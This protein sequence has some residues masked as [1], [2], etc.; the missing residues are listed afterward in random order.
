MKEIS[1][2]ELK[3]KIENK[4]DFQLIDVREDYEYEESNLKGEL[5]PLADIPD[6]MD[7]LSKDKPI[8]LYCKSGNRSS[9]ALQ[10]LQ[11]EGFKNVCMLTGGL[12]AWAKEI[13][14]TL[15]VY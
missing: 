14:T 7:K 2:Q 9:L 10:Y 1:A 8:I 4:E 15:V 12:A 6:N 11:D 13:D 5:I 3:L